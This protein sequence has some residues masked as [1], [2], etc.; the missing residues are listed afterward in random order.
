M[1]GSY[2]VQIATSVYFP[3]SITLLFEDQLRIKE[4]FYPIS[5]HYGQ[6]T[7]TVV[8]K[9]KQNLLENY[10]VDVISISQTYQHYQEAFSKP[11]CTASDE[12][13]TCFNFYKSS[14]HNKTEDFFMLA[15]TTFPPPT[16][17]IQNSLGLSS[18]VDFIHYHVPWDRKSYS[19]SYYQSK[20]RKP[21]TFKETLLSW[22]QAL[23]LCNNSGGHLPY[24]TSR[25]EVEDVI[26]MLKMA[27]QVPY[28]EALFVG[29]ISENYPQVSLGTSNVL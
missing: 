11:T 25:K 12:S 9:D 23:E 3:K 21:F 29:S 10:T 2:S 17:K 27:E 5:L 18:P 15:R 7:T 20:G 14:N 16:A 19:A 24:F 1:S 28:I 22:N 26:A 4:G 13:F 6:E 8:I